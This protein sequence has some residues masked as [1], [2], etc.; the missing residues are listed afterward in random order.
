MLLSEMTL[1]VAY[2]DCKNLALVYP[3]EVAVLWYTIQQHHGDPRHVADGRQLTDGR[4][5][6][7]GD[8]LSEMHPTGIV[9][10]ALPYLTPEIM[11]QIEV[12][13]MSEVESLIVPPA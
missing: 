10:W 9:G 8:L 6:L 7:G 12:V 13:S 3:Y 1:P 2:K 11:A 4:W 5:I